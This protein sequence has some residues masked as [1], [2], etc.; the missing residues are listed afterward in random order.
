MTEASCNKKV[1]D[2]MD[3]VPKRKREIVLRQ[4]RFSTVCLDSG[5]RKV[6]ELNKSGAAIL[7]LCDG[8]SSL[9]QIAL[10]IRQRFR[11]GQNEAEDD[12]AGFV[13]L[14]KDEG[15]VEFVSQ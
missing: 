10:A 3:V 15:I 6:F 4:T 2:I 5:N 7:G 12:V 11:I 14:M 13:R 8:R 9:R 1:D